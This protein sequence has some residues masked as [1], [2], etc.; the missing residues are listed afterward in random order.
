[1]DALTVMDVSATETM[2]KISVP[3]VADNTQTDTKETQR[4]SSSQKTIQNINLKIKE[5]DNG[6]KDC[7]NKEDNSRKEAC[8]K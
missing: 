5:N 1:M 8:S 3:N 6:Y 4:L 2:I 7:R